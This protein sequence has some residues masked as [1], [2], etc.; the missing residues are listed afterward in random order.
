[1]KKKFLFLMLI[2]IFMLVLTACGGSLETTVNLNTDLSGTRTMKYVI[3]KSDFAE[4]VSGD[5]TAVDATIQANVPEGLTYVLSED[6]IKALFFDYAYKLYNNKEDIDAL[7]SA[8]AD[9]IRSL[10]KIK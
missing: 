3:T 9:G 2:T 1:M 4:Y 5:I 8:L 6:E 7:V 10:V